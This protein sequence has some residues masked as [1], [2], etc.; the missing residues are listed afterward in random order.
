[1]NTG[2]RE[3]IHKPTEGQYDKSKLASHAFEEGY[4]IDWT[5]KT[6]WQFDPKSIYRK[7]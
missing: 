6:M 5:N 7:Y 4:Q 1:L 2:I 3:Q